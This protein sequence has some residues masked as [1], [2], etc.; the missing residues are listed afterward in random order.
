MQES[1]TPDTEPNPE[2]YVTGFT[3]PRDDILQCLAY[4][5]KFYGD[6]RTLASWRQ[7]LPSGQLGSSAQVVLNA[8]EGA[9]FLATLVERE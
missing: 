7:G 2:V 5:A 3:P 1:V 4:I 9:G 6:E 8:A